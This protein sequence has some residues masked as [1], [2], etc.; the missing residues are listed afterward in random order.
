MAT[1]LLGNEKA[2]ENVDVSEQYP[3]GWRAIPG[4]QVTTV[5]IPDEWSLADAFR[6]VTHPGGVWANHSMA[7]APSWVESNDAALASLLASQYN[8]PVGR[9]K[10]WD[11]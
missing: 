3:D 10:G 7:E 2:G 5:T 1:V 6:T 11:K 4:K 9:P 8:C